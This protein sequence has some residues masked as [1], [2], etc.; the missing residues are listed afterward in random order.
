[1]ESLVERLKEISNSLIMSDFSE[2]VMVGNLWKVV[3]FHYLTKNPRIFPKLIKL[4]LIRRKE[5]KGTLKI[6][7]EEIVK[8]KASFLKDIPYNKVKDAFNA[9]GTH[10]LSRINM[11]FVSSILK[12][13]KVLNIDEINVPF[14]TRDGVEE[15]NYWFDLERK[16]LGRR[17]GFDTPRNYLKDNGI[18]IIVLG[19]KY[20]KRNGVYT[21][22]IGPS[23]ENSCLFQEKNLITA[24]KLDYYLMGGKRRIIMIDNEEYNWITRKGKPD[25]LYLINIQDKKTLDEQLKGVKLFLS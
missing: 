4:D 17:N 21:G 18:H 6:S 24:D 8:L 10:Y 12:I 20:E 7:E 9:P 23:T 15:V 3:A 14:I 5:L 11:S 25:N 13:K 19:N 22:K 1:M 2:V 16:E